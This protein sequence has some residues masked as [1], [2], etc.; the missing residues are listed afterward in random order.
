VAGSKLLLLNHPIDITMGISP[1]ESFSAVTD[2]YGNGTRL[3][4]KRGF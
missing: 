3:Y 4:S 2:Y 1:P